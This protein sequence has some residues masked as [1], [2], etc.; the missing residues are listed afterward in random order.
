MNENG[1]GKVKLC[2]YLL[3]LVMVECIRRWQCHNCE[4]IAQISRSGKNVEC[5]ERKFDGHDVVSFCEVVSSGKNVMRGRLSASYR[6]GSIYTA[7]PTYTK[8]S[9]GKLQSGLEGV[10]VE[11]AVDM[12]Y[13]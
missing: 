5:D 13:L 1:L 10:F 11:L 8:T 4:R 12:K 9:F 6:P 7:C 2:C 3:Q